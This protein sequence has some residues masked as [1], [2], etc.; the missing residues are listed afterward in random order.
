[1]IVVGALYV[2]YALAMIPLIIPVAA[3]IAWWKTDN[4]ID[5]QWAKLSTWIS[6]NIWSKC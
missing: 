1:M 2:Y 6:E 4:W 5:K 3:A